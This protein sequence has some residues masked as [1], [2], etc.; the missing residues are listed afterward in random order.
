MFK[1]IIF[2]DIDGV[3]NNLHLDKPFKRFDGTIA[4]PVQGTKEFRNHVGLD[5]DKVEHLNFI[6]ES[7]PDWNIVI[8]SSWGYDIKKECTTQKFLRHFGFKYIDRIL[9]ETGKGFGRG[10]QILRFVKENNV[11][12]FVTI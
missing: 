12:N 5:Y 4:Q 9:N 6:M 8:S 2:L 7:L 10:D 11:Y 1:N 3:L